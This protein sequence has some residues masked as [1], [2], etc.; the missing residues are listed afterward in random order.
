MAYKKYND[1]YRHNDRPEQADHFLREP[2]EYR[3]DAHA[4]TPVK[5]ITAE[6][7]KWLA[8]RGFHE[9]GL[10]NGEQEGMY[11]IYLRD[12]VKEALGRNQFG[13][14]TETFL[15]IARGCHGEG[16]AM[17]PATFRFQY[18]LD[19]EQEQ[20][21]LQQLEVTMKG[22]TTQYRPRNYAELPMLAECYEQID[23]QLS[24]PVD[25]RLKIARQIIATPQTEKMRRLRPV[26]PK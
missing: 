9:E 23:L 25:K 12:Q 10:R 19:C 16:D 3:Q 6:A 2:S 5:D 14:G 24:L 17:Q 15:V 26:K 8:A 4:R 20:L 13:I 11:R 1:P 18:L 22:A 21:R 7:E